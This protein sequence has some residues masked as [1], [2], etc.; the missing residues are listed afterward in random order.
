MEFCHEAGILSVTILPGIVHP[1]Q[2]V[3]DTGALAVDVFHEFLALACE[4]GVALVTEAHIGCVFE[5][6]RSALSLLERVPGLGI[7]L[8]Y[9]HF[10]CQGYVQAEADPL[11]AYAGHVHLRQAKPGLLQTRL[12]D[13]TINFPLVL[14]RLRQAEYDRYLCIEYVHTPYGGANNVDVLTET[15]KM[16]D[17]LN[18]YLMADLQQAK[19][20]H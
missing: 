5:S 7:V 1:G 17:S 15:V 4:A 10:L 14:D 6:P 3:A 2:A 20:V 12:E 16:R 8:D 13:G 19:E 18:A 11:C 9:A